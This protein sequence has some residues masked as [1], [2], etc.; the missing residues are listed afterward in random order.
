MLNSGGVSNTILILG[1]SSGLSNNVTATSEI[2]TELTDAIPGLE[3]TKQ[4]TTTD[5]NGNNKVDLGDIIV[6]TITA[7]NTEMLNSAVYRLPIQCLTAYFGESLTLSSGPSYSSS[8]DASTS[9]EQ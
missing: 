8:T 5:V 2:P 9:Q 1:S 6:Y 3:L 4:F 7:E